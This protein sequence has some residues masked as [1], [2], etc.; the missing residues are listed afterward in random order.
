MSYRSLL[1]DLED[2]CIARMQATEQRI[3]TEY[4][5]IASAA[6]EGTREL[7]QDRLDM[8]RTD[9]HLYAYALAEIRE[10]RER[11]EREMWTR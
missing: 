9:R 8:L 5:S 3:A 6:T 2:A 4:E 10:R 7:A 1:L 11:E